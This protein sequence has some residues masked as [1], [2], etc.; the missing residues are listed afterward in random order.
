MEGER[1]DLSPL[2]APLSDARR[3][4]MVE[5]ILRRVRP[6]LA[7]RA[8]RAGL[9]GTLG[10]WLWPAMA[11]AALAAVLSGAVLSRTMNGIDGA[12]FAGGVVPAL[13]VED[14]VSA[15]LDEERSPQVSDL[16]LALERGGR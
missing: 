6:E 10:D 7:R 13:D 9:L 11:A 2:D 3:E 5:H 1:L 16:I 14:P 12:A 4:R 15:W 8:A